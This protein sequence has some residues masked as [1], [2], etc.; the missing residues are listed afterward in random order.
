MASGRPSTEAEKTKWARTEA[1]KDLKWAEQEYNKALR[2]ND[3]DAQKKAAEQLNQARRV[4]KIV[5]GFEG[6]AATVR[7]GEQRVKRTYDVEDEP[8]EEP[9]S[10]EKH[11]SGKADPWLFSDTFYRDLNARMTGRPVGNVYDVHA[12]EAKQLMHQKNNEAARQDMESQDAWQRGTRNEYAE[13]GKEASFKNDAQNRQQINNT[14]F[15]QG[16]GAARLRKT[17]EPDI[18]HWQQ[19]GAQQ[20]QL[21]QQRADYADLNRENAIGANAQEQ[22][23]RINSRDYD[24]DSN[25]SRRLS[26]GRGYG[27]DRQRQRPVPQPAPQPTPEPEPEPEPEQPEQQLPSGDAQHVM[28]ALLGS[29]K[30]EDLRNGTAT[31]DKELYD[32]VLNTYNVKP[33]PLGTYE[34]AS[35]G[36]PM[37]YE[38]LWLN[39]QNYSGDKQGAV[40][41]LRSGRVKPGEDSSKNFS[42]SDDPEM[43]HSMTIPGAQA[44]TQRANPVYQV[45][46]SGR[47]G[48]P[49]NVKGYACGTQN[50]EPGLA[51]V[52]ENGPELVNFNGGEQVYPM[53][54][55]AFLNEL[56]DE[57]C[58]IIKRK[59]DAGED[60]S[61]NELMFLADRAGSDLFDHRD[62]TDYDDDI[63][64]GYAEHIRNYL[65]NYKPGSEN[66]DPRIDP[67]EEH[68]GPMAQD[69]EKVNP[70]CVKETPEGVKT[71]DAGR[72][73][74]MNAGAIGDLARQM[75]DLATRLEEIYGAT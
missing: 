32:Y 8:K 6:D 55:Q 38:D 24:W 46:S 67:N 73:A 16:T 40:N 18:R 33:A 69:I 22:E 74:M 14:A 58:K 1:D 26:L 3:P 27:S 5:N 29:S 13:A 72:L 53:D 23:S 39:D 75:K 68:I 64:N 45:Q 60:L 34:Q 43:N 35:G 31:A 4:H 28:N 50:A 37:Q 9:E 56:C 59:Y 70:A 36:D 44:Q 2:E 19:Y 71:V 62:D 25:E 66:I 21:G 65:Y 30:G 20:R 7:Y 15:A 42:G 52:G 57:R 11:A 54:N 49:S 12:N 47:N 48:M 17:T 51:M 63:L 61:N 10:G 41:L